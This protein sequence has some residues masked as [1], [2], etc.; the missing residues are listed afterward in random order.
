MEIK[1]VHLYNYTLIYAQHC[2]LY[3]KNRECCIFI[4]CGHLAFLEKNIKFDLTLIRRSDGY[5]YDAFILNHETLLFLKKIL[6]PTI[7]MS[8]STYLHKRTLKDKIFKIK[9]ISVALELFKMLKNG[10]GGRARLYKL[11]YILSKSEDLEELMASINTS[12][13]M[14]FS[15]R[16]RNLLNSDL[17][18]KWKISD[19]SD[20][21]YMSEITIRKKLEKE[22]ICFNQLLLDVRMHKAM[23][24][25]LENK[26]SIS[27]IAELLGYSSNSYFIKIF[28]GYYGITPKQ[29]NIKYSQNYLSS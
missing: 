23:S 26:L 29:F 8:T 6:E 25:M 18:K 27:Q 17:S 14:K 24:Y 16:I 5:L 7:K 1:N 3:L 13:S 20:K 4:P 22:A 28:K 10:K 11:A 2:D 9:S 21:L 19:L 12:I 15:E